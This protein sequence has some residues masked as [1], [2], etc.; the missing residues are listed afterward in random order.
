MHF[1]LNDAFYGTLGIERDFR[2]TP[3]TFPPRRERLDL[4]SLEDGKLPFLT[5]FIHRI[6]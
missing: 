3:Q 5:F 4:K 1:S 6:L 2:D